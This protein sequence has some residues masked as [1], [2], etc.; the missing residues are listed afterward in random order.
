MS[1]TLGF[2]TNTEQGAGVF[3][4]RLKTVLEK[5]GVF[6]A[7]RPKAWIQLPFQRLPEHIERY[8]REGSTQVL[9]RLSGCFCNRYSPLG[10]PLP[11]IDTMYSR[12]LNT[13]KNNPLKEQIRRS[14]GVIHQTGFS[15]KLIQH[16][17][18]TPRWKTII[19]N[20]IPLE[21]YPLQGPIEEAL[22]GSFDIL[23]CHTHFQ[24]FHRIHDAMKILSALK[25]KFGSSGMATGVKLHIVGLDDGKSLPY[26]L[27][28]AKNLR[29]EEHQDFVMWGYP[30]TEKLARLYRSCDLL[31]NLSYWESA[32]NTV[33]E[34][35]AF[36]LPVVGVQSGGVAEWVD[37]G[38]VLVKEAIPFT[39]WDHHNVKH[40][41]QAPVQAYVKAILD[42][43]TELDTYKSNA[44]HRVETVFN[45]E[46][47][48]DQY[49]Q[50][51]KNRMPI[52]P[53]ELVH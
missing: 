11:L 43:M 24:P 29:L 44:R 4:N 10:V 7:D 41:P 42:L 45:I 51:A 19:P 23:V 32:P 46:T 52:G 13:Q 3:L 39:V 25:K 33:I 30:D 9:L 26:A 6:D 40:V 8:H 35:M 21:E 48:A 38:G 20:G 18:G 5:R 49:I 12:K 34:A 53:K 31:L 16:F 47:V 17:V 36:G 14:D 2:E 22:M 37:D 15:Q 28:V 1:V 50:A 27:S